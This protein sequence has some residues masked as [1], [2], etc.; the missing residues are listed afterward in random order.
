M[1]AVIYFVSFFLAPFGLGY[2]FKYLKSG[3]KIERRVGYIALA[4][5]ILAIV[6]ELWVGGAFFNAQ[7]Q[8]LH[9]L[10]L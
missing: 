3:G 7:V 5:T 6:I 2:V 9:E 1:Q 4:L 10:G 8:A